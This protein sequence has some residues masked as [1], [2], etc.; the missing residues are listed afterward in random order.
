MY[1]IWN[2][3]NT[4]PSC[5]AVAIAPASIVGCPIYNMKLAYYGFSRCQSTSFVG[6]LL[7]QNP[8]PR[9]P[10]LKQPSSLLVPRVALLWSANALTIRWGAYVWGYGGICTQLILNISLAA[11]F[12]FDLTTCLKCTGITIPKSHEI[13][14]AFPITTC[15]MQRS[16]KN[17]FDIIIICLP[18]C[19][20]I[21]SHFAAFRL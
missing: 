21:C 19:F 7:Q 18:V 5:L 1:L 13:R 3:K 2:L 12:R 8:R 16:I 17:I 6:P 20:F 4:K 15:N 11:K 9:S 10:K 14:I